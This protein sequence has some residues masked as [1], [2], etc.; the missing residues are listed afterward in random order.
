MPSNVNQSADTIVAVSTPPGYSGIG[1]IRMS[2]P[3]S[4]DILANIFMPS[5]GR[6]QI[7]DRKAL[8]G[9]V[10]DP[11]S[12]LVLDDGIALVMQGPRS[13]TG[14]DVVELS[15]HGSPV[16]LDL[17]LRL[18]VRQGARPATRGEFTRRAFLAGRLD[19]VQ[20]EAVIDL[21]EAAGPAGAEEARSRLDGSLS[22]RIV[23]LSAALKDIIAVMEAHMDFDDDDEDPAPD[24]EPSIRKVFAK[25]QALGEL[26]E[27]GRVRREGIRTA[28]VG[29]PNVGKST[30]FNALLRAD[31]AIVTPYAGTTRDTLEERLVLGGV[32]LNLCDTAGI[33]KHPD[34]VETEGIRRTEEQMAA[35]DLILVVLDGSCAPD[36]EDA[37]V[38]ARCREERTVVVINK[39]DLGLVVKSGDPALGPAGRP[40]MAVS[41]KTGEG[42]DA[43]RRI[44]A[45]SAQD[46]ASL[47]PE[48]HAGGL[49]GRCLLLLEAAMVPLKTLLDDFAE[50]AIITPEIVSLEVRRALGPLEEITGER[51]DEGIL[52]RIFE[53]FCVGK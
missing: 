4:R 17:V 49:N 40:R 33:R 31:R 42:L 41:A 43:L 24:P 9:T 35:A 23:D 46:M 1:V 7:P 5:H 48:Q 16:V 19:L 3:D 37:A 12:K 21:I 11:Q 18:L 36:A 52:E 47:A 45:E 25:M 20:A 38:L 32:A 51:A 30:L 6:T 50:H 34:P 53:R 8:H 44:L 13:Y 22:N 10:V 39:T 14:E 29:K 15:L 26:S 2:G 27:L 28:V